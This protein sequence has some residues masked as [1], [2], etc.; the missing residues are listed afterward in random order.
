MI[1]FVAPADGAWEM[2]EYLK[3]YGS[4]LARRLRIVT[5][6]D[7]VE[8]RA[9]AL[10]TYVFSALDQLCPTE[11]EIAAR[12]WEELSRSSQA[13]TLINHPAEALRRYELLAVCFALR[14]NVFRVCRAPALHRALTFP[15]FIRPEREHTGSL[16]RLLYDRRQLVR[17]ILTA[18][19]S[20]Y[21]LRDLL[22]VEYCD[23]V[24]P[25]G[26]YRQYCA[27]IVGERIIPQVLVHN[28]NWVTKWKGRLVDADKVREQQEYV[29]GH[30]HAEWLK[31]TFELARIRYGRIDYGLKDGVPQVWEI[32][33]NPT[34]V[35]RAANP[36]TMP[37]AQ[38]AL[39]EPMRERFLLRFQAALEVIDTDADPNR[40]IRIDV[41]RREL[42][43]LAAERR[44]RQRLRARRTAIARVAAGPLWLARRLRATRPP[45]LRRE[46]YTPPSGS[47][48]G[49][50]RE[51]PAGSAPRD[52][53]LRDSP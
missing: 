33:T 51:G 14:R 32:N 36:S 8:Q 52:A 25:A 7:I 11:R 12:C 35:R 31:T 28:H 13:L 48:G 17:G 22:V 1:F 50:A 5:Y 3:Q 44:L 37:A 16:T 20:G 45:T 19:A 41:S 23:T 29:E 26:V 24:D 9:L 53:A 47:P 42:R 40:T 27:T 2:E 18:L 21:R 6:E 4:K 38:R 49:A 15:V 43:R 34:I 30:P 39:L 46:A 10:G